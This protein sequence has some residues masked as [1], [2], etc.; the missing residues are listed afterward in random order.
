MIKITPQGTVFHLRNITALDGDM[1]DLLKI[2]GV[3]TNIRYIDDGQIP[4]A[5]LEEKEIVISRS[6]RAGQT[7]TVKTIIN[8]TRIKRLKKPFKLRVTAESRKSGKRQIRKRDFT[9]TSTFKQALEDA[10]KQRVLL[11]SEAETPVSSEVSAP[12]SMQTFKEAL[13][14]Q[15]KAK[16][17]KYEADNKPYTNK[18]EKRYSFEKST[19]QFS[20]KWLKP[21]HNKKLD[22]ITEEDL[23]S[24]MA[25]M[26]KPDGTPL[27]LRTKRTVYQIVNPV[28]TWINKQ[29]G[30]SIDSPAKVEDLKKPDNERQCPYDVEDAEEGEENK[31]LELLKLQFRKLYYYAL[32]RKGKR[33]HDQI[34]GVYIWLMHGRRLNEV[35]SLK[36]EHLNLDKNTYKIVGDNNKARKDMD[37]ILTGYQREAIGKPK[38]KGYVFH[39]INDAKKALSKETIRNHDVNLFKDGM[40]KHDL[41]H[42]IGG[43]LIN[44]GTLKEV[45]GVILGHTQNKSITDRYAKVQKRTANR[46]ILSMLDDLLG[47]CLSKEEIRK[48][49]E[50]KE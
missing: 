47:A 22:E 1:T 8:Y 46:A 17:M 2:E 38:K 3:N 35:L 36:W 18:K 10:E 40:H 23:T 24:I 39:A 6:K 15:L 11:L 41:R 49:K 5:N 13:K 25:K 9:Y 27:A 19:P 50:G 48:T 26:R 28:Y 16:K 30:F 34:R 33:T 31:D 20:E 29:K 43:Y 45:I 12:T 14:K 7:T 37:Y 4:K 32:D 42:C 21:I 44:K